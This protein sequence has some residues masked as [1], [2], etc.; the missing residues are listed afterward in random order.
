MTCGILGYGKVG[1]TIAKFYDSPKIKDLDRND[2]LRGAE[3]LH[4]CIPWNDNFV[5]IVNKEIDSIKPKLTIIHSTVP[6]GTTKGIGGMIAHSPI[7]GVHPNLYEG[8]KTFVKYVGADNKEAGEMAKEHLESLGI[9][10]KV[11]MPSMTTEA[12]KLF[13][14][15]QY[16]WMIILNKEIKKW[17]DEKGLDFNAVYTEPNIDYNESYLKL[18]RPEVVRPFL[19]Y[20]PGRIGGHCVIRN[21]ELLDNEIAKFILNKNETYE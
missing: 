9:K 19:K 16:G 18:G 14:T 15:A 5:E 1:R 3:I 2:D 13:D 4:I 17:C 20:I 10:V 8:V 7:R 11:F 21:C 12:L 6:V